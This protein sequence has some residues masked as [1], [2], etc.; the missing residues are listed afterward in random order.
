[1]VLPRLLASRKFKEEFARRL[2]LSGPGVEPDWEFAVV[3]A[4]CGLVLADDLT[5]WEVRWKM[6]A[7]GKVS[8]RVVVPDG[9]TSWQFTALA[10]SIRSHPRT[11]PGKLDSAE[12][13]HAFVR[14]YG[15]YGS[16]KIS[17]RWLAR[18]TGFDRELI[19]QIKLRLMAA[20]R[21]QGDTSS[22]EC[23]RRGKILRQR[24]C[25][26]KKH[27]ESCP[28]EQKC[29]PVAKPEMANLV[30][31]GD[32][33]SGVPFPWNPEMTLKEFFAGKTLYTFQRFPEGL[34]RLENPFG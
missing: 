21:L 13:E 20:G 28:D 8:V 12:A 23:M 24:K 18:L 5:R 25:S 14:L 19:G 16:L 30:I 34:Q 6:C 31:C 9:E 7:S 4:P 27:S 26:G 11:G 32:T 33:Q 29:K 2:S 22:R 17:D 1:M 15:H 3:Q 10:E